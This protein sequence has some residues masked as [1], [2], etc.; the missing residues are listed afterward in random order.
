MG[1]NSTRETMKWW[2]PHTNKLKYFSS[3]KFDEHKNKFVKGWLP[4]STLMNDKNKSARSTLELIFQ[5]T[6]SSK[7]VYL[8]QQ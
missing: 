7:M 3:A 2:E 5:T 4:G 6:P 8:R 1:Y